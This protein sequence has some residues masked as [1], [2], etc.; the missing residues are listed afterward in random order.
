[1]SQNTGKRA[2]M[3]A[4]TRQKILQVALQLFA[5]RGYFGTSI[6][7]IARRC[8][9]SK[10]LI[11]HYFQNKQE[12]LVAILEEGMQAGHELL[13]GLDEIPDPYQQ[14][15]VMIERSFNEILRN[16]AYWRLYFHVLLQSMVLELFRDKLMQFYQE[17]THY[18]QELLKKMGVSNPD[19]EARLLIALLDG[20]GLH[21]FLVGKEFPLAAVKNALIQRYA[22]NAQSTSD[23]TDSR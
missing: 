10:G 21:Y 5:E 2:R 7:L 16:E 18:F 9:I 3:R 15:A 17:F 1:M 12:I 22:R 13:K 20:L 4:A 11:Y 6:D 14:F 19:V 8:Q 23:D